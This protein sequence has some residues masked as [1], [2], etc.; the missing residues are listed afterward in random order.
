MINS[1]SE[2]SIENVCDFKYL[3]EMTGG[4]KYLIK[5]LMD[6]FI[7]QIS[8]ELQSINDAIIKTDYPTIKN[9][10]H[11]M[12]SSVSIMGISVLTPVLQEMEELAKAASD[13]ERI[14]ELNQKLHVIC[15]QALEE[16]EREKGNYV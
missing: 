10:A 1:K 6:A 12:K 4:K 8:E 9:I 14:K 2:D 5:D 11:T 16:I 3:S 15:K 7:K 13:I